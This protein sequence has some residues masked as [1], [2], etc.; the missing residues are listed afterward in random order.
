MDISN[1]LR[2]HLSQYHHLNNVMVIFPY[3]LRLRVSSQCLRRKQSQKAVNLT[4]S[5]EPHPSIGLLDDDPFAPSWTL[6]REPSWACRFVEG[7][8]TTPA[9]VSNQQ[10]SR[11][12][13]RSRWRKASRGASEI[14]PPST[15]G[16]QSSMKTQSAG[17]LSASQ[18]SVAPIGGHVT[19]SLMMSGLNSSCSTTTNFLSPVISGSGSA[20]GQ[21]CRRQICRRHPMQYSIRSSVG[22]RTFGGKLSSVDKK[23]LVRCL[24]HHG[25]RKSTSSLLEDN[26]GRIG[27]WPQEVTQYLHTPEVVLQLQLP[28]NI[29]KMRNHELHL[30]PGWSMTPHPDKVATGGADSFYISSDFKCLALADG[31]GEWDDLG[32]SPRSYTDELMNGIK[33]VWE[34]KDHPVHSLYDKGLPV[35]LIAKELMLLASKQPTSY[36]SATCCVRLAL[37]EMSRLGRLRFSMSLVRNWVFAIWVIREW[38]YCVV[39]RS[40]KCYR[41]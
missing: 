36:G 41:D 29:V 14:L 6:L 22:R 19:E 17:S 7:S 11:A 15:A 18:V 40:T 8:R 38:P 32:F 23:S 27:D 2:Q 20:T 31:V 13:L 33:K 10:N 12:L 25:G 4:P 26:G 5:C 37:T 39:G 35:S 21:E 24:S 30:S 34:S 1:I 9:A 28:G 3:R 16:L